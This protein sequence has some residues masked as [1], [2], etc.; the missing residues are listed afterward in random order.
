MS[1]GRVDA[2][3]GGTVIVAPV[4]SG[5]CLPFGSYVARFG[6]TI[7][8]M[9]SNGH[10]AASPIGPTSVYSY[11]GATVIFEGPAAH[12]RVDAQGGQ[13][14]VPTDALLPS[15]QCKGVAAVVERADYSGNLC[16]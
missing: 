2:N 9:A 5:D 16:P 12:L 7:R 6:S 3:R 11:L 1:G 13:V 8:V 14:Y 10:C 4:T 15:V